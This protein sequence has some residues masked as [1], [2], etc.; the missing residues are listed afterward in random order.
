VLEMGA[1]RSKYVVVSRE[2]NSG[3]NHHIIIG[4]V[5]CG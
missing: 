4:Y 3:Q 2:Q 5:E 1:D